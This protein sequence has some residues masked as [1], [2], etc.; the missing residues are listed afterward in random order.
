MKG[1]LKKLTVFVTIAAITIFVVAATASAGDHDRK[2][3]RGVYGWA[4]PLYCIS[5]PDG[6]SENG[7]PYNPESLSSSSLTAQGT[8]TFKHDGTGKVQFTGV[9][10][11]PPGP[12]A[13]AG[14]YEASYEHTY[15][16]ASNG[17]ITIDA[18]PNT[19]VQN[20][21]TGPNKGAV[22]YID[23]WPL[24]GWVSADYKTITIA[25]PEPTIHINTIVLPFDPPVRLISYS[26][27]NAS[28]TLVR[29]GGH[30]KDTE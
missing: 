23:T 18:V 29:I 17:A 14:L 9:G 2:T 27:C 12:N 7:I 26:I 6:F 28:F 13:G 3:I 8:I 10:I 16:I 25:G 24:T 11:N 20:F 5:T 22:L 19:F 21:L 15:N 1:S 4:G 30:E